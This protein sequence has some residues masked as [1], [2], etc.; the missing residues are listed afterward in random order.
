[1]ARDRRLDDAV[2]GNSKASLDVFAFCKIAF[3]R[4]GSRITSEMVSL[5]IFEANRLDESVAVKKVERAWADLGRDLLV[6]TVS[7]EGSRQFLGN[8]ALNARDGGVGFYWI[9]ERDLSELFV[10]G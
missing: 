7:V 4:C 9:R 6:G 10:G 8:L 1:M 5:A 3:E 2:R